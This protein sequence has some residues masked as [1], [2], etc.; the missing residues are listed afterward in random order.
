MADHRNH[1]EKYLKGELSPAEMNALERQALNDPFLADALEGAG[2]IPPGHLAADI[3]Q[4]QRSLESRTQSRT[5]TIWTW[6]LRIAAGLL[7]L[8]VSTFVI[9]SLVDRRGNN[10]LALNRKAPSR[11]SADSIVAP[12]QSVTE[13]ASRPKPAVEETGEGERATARR[14][15]P[16]A[17]SGEASPASAPPSASPATASQQPTE[18][19]T[20]PA[21]PATKPEH[22]DD[23]AE[24]KEAVPALQGYTDQPFPQAEK[25]KADAGSESALSG[26]APGVAVQRSPLVVSGKVTSEDG[27]GLPGVNVVISGTNTGT[28]TDSEG[29][30]VLTMDALE[31]NTLVFSFI[32]MQSKEAQLTSPAPLNI[33]LEPDVSELSEVVVV[34]FGSDVPIAEKPSYQLE[35]ASPAGGR[36]AFKKYLETNMRYPQQALDNKVEGRV[37]V[38]FT[39]ETTGRLSDFNVLKGIGYGC[40]EEVIRLIKS[41]PKWVPTK[42][43]EEP[44]RDKVKVRLRFRLPKK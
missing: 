5:L 16:T 15:A 33:V 19:A 10:D 24:E 37:T 8:A 40:D 4:L 14:Q 7:L 17:A 22:D 27:V 18:M 38:Q 1:I 36:G 3:Q 20:E 43:D 28:L 2:Q 34:G 44:V 6:P 35:F 25:R 21:A 31:S 39:V 13:P 32:G 29:N 26:R 12:K 42:H 11:P 41:G 30:Y 9:F 23:V